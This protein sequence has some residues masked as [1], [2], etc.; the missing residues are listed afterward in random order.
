MDIV[1]R[2]THDDYKDIGD[3][4]PTVGAFRRRLEQLPRMLKPSLQIVWRF[5]PLHRKKCRNKVI[6]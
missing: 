5:P 4:V 1:V 3:R 6:G 2:A